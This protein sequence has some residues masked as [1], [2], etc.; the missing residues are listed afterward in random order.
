MPCKQFMLDLSGNSAIPSH[1]MLGLKEVSK[2]I[3]QQ[4]IGYDGIQVTRHYYQRGCFIVQTSKDDVA[5]F[6]SSFKLEIKVN[7]KTH[8][9][10]LRRRL[11]NGPGTKVRFFKTCEDDFADVPCS[12]FDDILTAAGWEVVSP[13]E[14]LVHEGTNVYDGVRMATVDRGP[15]HLERN[16]EFTNENGRTYKWRLE[17]AGQPFHCF[18]GCGVFHED[19]KCGEWERRRNRRKM[20]GQ[21]KCFVV[22]SSVLRLASDTKNVNVAAIPGAKVGHIANHINNKWHAPNS[23]NRLMI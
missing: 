10:P 14:Y 21:Q 2:W 19:G 8:V 23:V 9:V 17:Y 16:H 15:R 12:Y 20:E 6:L 7:G 3:H 18:L 22:S 13:T 1:Y 4:C 5:Q 11:A